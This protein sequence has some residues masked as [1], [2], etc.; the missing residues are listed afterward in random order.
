MSWKP[1]IVGVD[2]SAEAARA[3]TFAA[4][5]A[6]VAGAA[7]R[8]VHAA[9]DPWTVLPSGD[10]PEEA[11]RQV[12]ALYARARESVSRALR[13]QVAPGLIDRLWV[14]AGRAPVALRQAA[15]EVD[16]ELIVVGGK[17]H[18][19]VSEWMGGSTAMHL[20]RTSERPVLVATSASAPRRIFVAVDA[21]D[22]AARTVQAAERYARLL[23][24]RLKVLSVIEPLQSVGEA[25]PIME[26]EPYYDTARGFIERQVWGA[27]DMADAER[28]IVFG[29][30]ADA[31]AREAR[32]WGAD[33][34]VVG[35]HG[36][37][38]VERV[39]IGSVTRRLVHELPTSVLVVPVYATLATGPADAGAGAAVSGPLAGVVGVG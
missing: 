21:S 16:A 11:R 12:E 13:G 27:I 1:I 15:A 4:G 38:W 3:A 8:L 25:V 14:R 9:P 17:H 6:E 39:L 10:V 31:I 33:L 7:C 22:A 5:L 34:L 37:G 28:E 23:N 2:A 32:T 24:A 18:S 29:P 20:L 36:K 19:V 30:A 35:S 26:V